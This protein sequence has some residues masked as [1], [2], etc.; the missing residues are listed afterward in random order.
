ME[1]P[2][3]GMSEGQDGK[4]GQ[5]AILFRADIARVKEECRRGICGYVSG[6]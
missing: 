5:P 2:Q 4:S 6:L 3:G 1:Y